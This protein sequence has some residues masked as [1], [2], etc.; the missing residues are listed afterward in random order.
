MKTLGQRIKNLR[1]HLNK[2]QD[3]FAALCDMSTNS[4]SKI[5]NDLSKPSKKIIT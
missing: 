4:L 5:E 1:E 2:R 3:Q